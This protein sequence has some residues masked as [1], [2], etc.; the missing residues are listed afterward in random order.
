LDVARGTT[1]KRI[2]NAELV[3]IGKD[4]LTK[5]TPIAPEY[6]FEEEKSEGV[7]ILEKIII[8]SDNI[9]DIT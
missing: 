2:S 4:N 3:R 9:S 1:R 6:R 8:M 5:I 7:E